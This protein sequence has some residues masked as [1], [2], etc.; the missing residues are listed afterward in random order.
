MELVAITYTST[1]EPVMR[2]NGAAMRV[3]TVTVHL[4]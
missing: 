4:V 2:L 1:F 3:Y